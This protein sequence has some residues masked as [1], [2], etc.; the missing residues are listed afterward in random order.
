VHELEL[1]VQA[2]SGSVT[3]VVRLADGSPRIEFRTVI[4]NEA[5]DHRLRAVFEV[6]DPGEGPVRA[7]G[8]FALVRR[9]LGPPAPRTEWVEP[10]DAT[11]HT[12]GAVALGPLALIARGLPEYEARDT[13]LCLT[14]LRSVGVISKPS[15]AIA[16]R[17]MGAGPGVETPEGQCLGRQDAEYAL[18]LGADGLDDLALLRESQDYRSGWLTLPAALSLEPRIGL[19]GPVVF[20]CLKGAEDGDGL[21]LRCFNPSGEAAVARVRGDVAVTRTRL[22]ETGSEPLANGTLELRPGEIGTVRL[23]PIR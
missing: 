1:R 17:P 21:I 22:D 18:V 10:P 15:G 23:R 14:L 4:D 6:G 11:Q 19:E 9:S 16:T 5:P 20:S 13:E 3:T 8:Q 12:C 2:P 7:E